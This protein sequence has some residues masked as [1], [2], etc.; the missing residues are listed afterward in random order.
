MKDFRFALL[1]M[2]FLFFLLFSCSNGDELFD[3]LVTVEEVKTDGEVTE[4]KEP[5][6]SEKP[7][8]ENG[9]E[10]EFAEIIEKPVFLG[11]EA[12]SG[13]EIIFEFSLPVRVVN[14]DFI[15]GVEIDTIE[16]GSIVKVNLLHGLLPGQH[17]EAD[18]K[19]EDDYG[20]SIE[21]SLPFYSKNNRVPVLQINELRTEY[22]GPS[23]RAEFIEFKMKS[24][25]NLGALR[26]FV[27]SNNK[28]PLVY[29]FKPV[30]VKEGEYVVLH[31]RTLSDLCKDEYGEDLDESGGTDSCPTARDFWIPGSTKLLRKT[32][33]VYVL[34][35]NNNV[36]TAI[37]LVEKL[38]PLWEKPHFA[39]AAEFLFSQGAWMSAEGGIP[40]PIDAVNSTGIGSALTRSISKNE[41]VED[42]GSAASWYITATGGVTPGL[43]NNPKRL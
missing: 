24:D 42:T 14:L 37:M 6:E 28:N 33:A 39:K 41:A 2:V 26:V 9:E 18:F 38:S 15:P 36:L 10:E 21:M 1:G 43:P 12:V 23:S 25:G 19:V 8:D 40:S 4:A 17:L 32:D 29:E 11:C 13:T 31:M 3:E 22:S 35:Q 5:A 30:E 20:N 34:D 27:A 16:E 7:E